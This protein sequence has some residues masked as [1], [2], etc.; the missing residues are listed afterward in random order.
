MFIPNKVDR[1]S[2][3]GGNISVDNRK[4]EPNGD[5]SSVKINGD[6][7]LPR[8]SVVPDRRRLA[9]P[10]SSIYLATHTT[11][12]HNF[13]LIEK[14]RG[15]LAGGDP[16]RGKPG[17]GPPKTRSDISSNTRFRTMPHI[18]P[19]NSSACPIPG[20]EPEGDVRCTDGV[21]V[22]LV[23]NSDVSVGGDRVIGVVY[24]DSTTGLAEDNNYSIGHSGKFIGPPHEII[25]PT[26]E[27]YLDIRDVDKPYAC[28]SI[29][30][31]Q[32][33]KTA[34][35]SY[36][37]DTHPGL[38]I[39]ENEASEAL[40][41]KARNTFPLEDFSNLD[42]DELENETMARYSFEN[43]SGDNDDSIVGD[44]FKYENEIEDL[45][46]F[47]DNNDDNI[48]SIFGDNFEFMKEVKDRIPFI[49][50]IGGN[51][52]DYILDHKSELQLEVTTS[53]TISQQK[54]T[55]MVSL[56]ENK[57]I[58]LIDHHRWEKMG[59][60]FF[61]EKKPSGIE[62]LQK[63]S[64]GNTNVNDKLKSIADEATARL[65]KSDKD[66]HSL[67]LMFYQLLSAYS[68]VD[69]SLEKLEKFY[70]RLSEFE[71]KFSEK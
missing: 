8:L 23:E 58:H 18:D 25:I 64:H 12:K 19:R 16:K 14:K 53:L 66:R 69:F 57:I 63:I 59:V 4:S 52:I 2:S 45:I 55:N 33:G 3:G 29:P 11:S 48:D 51:D 38:V 37:T 34:F 39:S 10:I 68:N 70:A 28:F 36:A 21:Y 13:K 17:E 22:N 27:D 7:G 50:E 67:T 71:M 31:T 20:N 15:L 49:N 42:R 9:D 65:N 32:K 44:N 43:C 26:I 6:K 1:K 56:I 60:G 5:P 46:P 62:H 61:S 41:A 24:T 30:L 35:H 40:E 54:I 47:G